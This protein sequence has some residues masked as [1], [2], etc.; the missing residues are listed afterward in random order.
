MGEVVIDFSTVEGPECKEILTKKGLELK[1]TLTTAGFTQTMGIDIQCKSISDK[2][3]ADILA[4]GLVCFQVSWMVIQVGHLFPR[5]ETNF[6]LL[7]P[8]N[9]S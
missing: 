3:K 5:I 8:D 1:C 2:S 7:I 4:K 6:N 9:H